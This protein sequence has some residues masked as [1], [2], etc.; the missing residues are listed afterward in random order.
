MY[1]DAHKSAHTPQTTY[2]LFAEHRKRGE[3]APRG[4]RG[5]VCTRMPLPLCALIA[6]ALASAAHA[7]MASLSA[8]GPIESL[9]LSGMWLGSQM[10]FEMSSSMA[11]FHSGFFSRMEAMV[12]VSICGRG[13]G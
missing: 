6:T 4:A 8:G 9:I 7:A 11:A 13:G 1:C 2:S 3:E 10:L 12:S 5:G